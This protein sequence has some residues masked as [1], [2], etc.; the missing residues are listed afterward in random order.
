MT[1]TEW[2]RNRLHVGV[3][4]PPE[5]PWPVQMSYH[6]ILLDE[7]QDGFT[8]LM[9]HRMI[10]GRL[11]YGKSMRRKP[12]KDYASACARMRLYEETGNQEHLVDA[13]NFLRLEF[14]H[15]T[16]PKAHWN[17]QDRV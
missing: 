14:R 6:E 8:R 3:G 15:P 5:T 9:H 4:L 17:P 10:M 12:G 2:I 11:R 7:A 13:A 16:H 1:N